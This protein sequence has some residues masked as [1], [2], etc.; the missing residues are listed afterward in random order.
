MT[1]THKNIEDKYKKLGKYF[2]INIRNK[3]NDVDINDVTKMNNNENHIPQ[4][5]SKNNDN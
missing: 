3:C 5:I 2:D 4:Y 1:K